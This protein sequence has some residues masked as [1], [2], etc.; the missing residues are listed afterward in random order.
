M[1][2]SHS[3]A[4][5]TR[6]ANPTAT[7]PAPHAEVD[8]QI[9]LATRGVVAVRQ[10]GQRSP[11]VGGAAGL[12]NPVV[13]HFHG[14]AFVAGGLDDGACVARLLADSGAVVLSL[15]Y[16]LAPV[17]PFPEGVEVGYEVLEWVHKHRVKLAGQG[18]RVYVAGEEAGGNIAAAVSV[19]AR[20][21]AQPPLAG[22]ILVSPMLDPCVGTP[23]QRDDVNRPVLCKWAEGWKQYLRCP[24]DAEHPY[25]VPGGSRR[26]AQLPPTLVMSGADDPMRDE[27]RAYAE[28]LGHAG[29]KVSYH[30]LPAVGWPESLIGPPVGEC[31]CAVPFREHL[32]EFFHPAATG[33]AAAPGC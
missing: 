23:S 18:A 26:L 2:S 21:R 27:A 33:A 12:G 19:I 7:S 14:G 6:T 17:H 31:A 16:P 29:I 22:Q 4:M 25:A 8:M 10:Y 13:L 11:R 28:K 32:R 9:Q 20:D 15:A 1:P 5:N 3:K 30:V 24:M